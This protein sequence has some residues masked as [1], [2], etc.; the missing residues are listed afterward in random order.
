MLHIVTYQAERNLK[1]GWSLP[2]R[3]GMVADQNCSSAGQSWGG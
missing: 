1:A 3:I 2:V